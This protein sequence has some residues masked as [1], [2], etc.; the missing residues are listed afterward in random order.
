MKLSD[1]VISRISEHTKH[2]FLISGGGCIHL[3]DSLSRSSIE[4]IP[5]LHEQG[6]SIAAESYSQYTNKLGVALVTTG[7]GSTNAVTGIASAWLDSIPVL[8]LTGQVQ[9]KDRVGNRGVRQM[10]FQEINT[11]SI[12]SSI[13]KY[14]VTIND[15]NTI[16]YHLDKALWLAM[17]GRPGP[18][19]IDIPL[20]VQAA[21]IDIDSIEGYN[22][23]EN[24]YDLS[25]MNNIVEALSK[26]ER[27]IVLVGNG[28]RLSNALPEFYDFIEKTGIPV[29]TTWKTL[30]VLEEDHPQYVGRPGGVGQRGANF[31][32]QNSDFILVIGARLDH[33]QLAY[34][35]HFFAR[36]AVKCIVD[37]DKNEINKL[38]INVDFPIES[39]AKLFLSELNK[40]IPKLNIS[41][42]LT[43]CKKLY[44]KYPVILSDYLETNK[45]NIN[46][47]AFI[48]YLSELLPENSLLIPGSS[49]ACSE[50]T[51]QAFKTKK[52]TR[53]YNSE[54]LGSMGFAIPASIAGCIASNKKETICIDGDGGFFMNIQE[55]ELAHRYNLPIKFFILNNNGYGSIKT[56]QNSHFGGNLVASDPSSG[57][58]LPSIELNALAYKIQYTRIENQNNLKEDLEKVLNIKGPVICELIIDPNHK[59]FPKASVYKKSDGSFS[60]RPMEDLAPFLEREEFLNNLLIKPI[61]YE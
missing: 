28:V 4:L 26:A 14:A 1:Y 8:L 54:G 40:R 35:P 45:S 29:L 5:T 25:S 61:E 15:P 56:T 46:N 3:V 31:N 48:E 32:Q 19:V 53:I 42:W 60:T 11:I 55:L 6:A 12:Y 16:K 23:I 39:D 24:V 38:E 49:G 44:E 2:V 22:V 20:D 10:G 43:H 7:P 27:P 17:N 52:G 30:D 59:T 18:V 57:L 34:Q 37:I 41:S 50:V 58:T 51:M 21:E 9:N 36:E 33:G 47:Y 13:T